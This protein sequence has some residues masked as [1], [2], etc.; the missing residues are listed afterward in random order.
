MGVS[1]CTSN[2]KRGIEAIELIQ[3]YQG[4]NHFSALPTVK[5]YT[6][7]PLMSKSVI[8]KYTFFSFSFLLMMR[9]PSK[10]RPLHVPNLVK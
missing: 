5:L 7:M 3:I 2:N 1:V 9:N 8:K 6:I 4:N 10:A